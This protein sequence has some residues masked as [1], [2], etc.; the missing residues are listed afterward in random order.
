LSTKKE[1]VPPGARLATTVRLAIGDVTPERNVGKIG[2]TGKLESWKNWG[3]S[4]CRGGA[5][6]GKKLFK[7]GRLLERANS[8]EDL[9]GGKEKRVKFSGEEGRTEHGALSM[10]PPRGL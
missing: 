7:G 9:S 6:E 2:Q 5:D 4:N 1:E 8:A 10:T 3:Q